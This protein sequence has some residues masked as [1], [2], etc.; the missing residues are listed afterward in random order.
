MS[1]GERRNWASG[2]SRL[3]QRVTS[4]LESPSPC[5]ADAGPFA[6]WWRCQIAEPSPSTD[7]E[8]DEAGLVAGR[9]P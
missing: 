5:S 4:V 1:D 8:A 6:G 2:G 9:R 3:N 7:D